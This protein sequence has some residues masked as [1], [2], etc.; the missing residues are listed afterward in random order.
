ME[1]PM[2]KHVV[3]ALAA[4]ASGLIIGASVHLPKAAADAATD[5]RQAENG[6]GVNER[7]RVVLDRNR[8]LANGDVTEFTGNT[9][10]VSPD[11]VVVDTSGGRVW[12]PRGKIAY[13]EAR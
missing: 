4:L 3:I 12:I 11:W 7:V 2:R 9:V 13:V 1:V 8:P 10:G 5:A 6:P